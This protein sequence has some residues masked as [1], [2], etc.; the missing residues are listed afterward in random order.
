MH[1]VI[2]A[3]TIKVANIRIPKVFLSADFLFEKRITQLR[4]DLLYIKLT[5]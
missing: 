1:T 5:Y 4:M 2:Y 3:Y